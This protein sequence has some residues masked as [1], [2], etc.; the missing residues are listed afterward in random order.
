MAFRTPMRALF[1]VKPIQIP[2]QTEHLSHFVV[3]AAIYL[4]NAVYAD[5]GISP[6]LAAS[7]GE[8]SATK[9]SSACGR[10]GGKGRNYVFHYTANGDQ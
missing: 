10:I 3:A 5:A 1:V 6:A 8:S 9:E 4:N 2:C 7:A